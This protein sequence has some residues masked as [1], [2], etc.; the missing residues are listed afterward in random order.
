MSIL[1]EEPS[2]YLKQKV[3]KRLISK[4]SYYGWLICVYLIQLSRSYKNKRLCKM[5]C[6]NKIICVI[7]F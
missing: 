4:N 2:I 7:D 5:V 6:F 1:N 3:Y